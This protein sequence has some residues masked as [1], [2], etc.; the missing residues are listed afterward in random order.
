MDEK[1]PYFPAVVCKWYLEMD[2]LAQ[3]HK[4][5]SILTFVWLVG[6]GTPT[7]LEAAELCVGI[8]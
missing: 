8:L 6:K 1:G 5:G 4:Q 3:I 7:Q 2:E